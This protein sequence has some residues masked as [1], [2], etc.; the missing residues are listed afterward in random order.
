MIYNNVLGIIFANADEEALS[1]ITGIRSIGSVPFGGGYRLI[2]FTLSN[3]VNAG[4][5]KV[6]I[7][8]NNNYQSL[9]DHLGAGKPW[10]LSRRNEG[11]FLLPPFN[12]DAVRNYNAGR[13]GALKNAAHFLEKSNEEYALLSDCSYV[14]NIDF[15]R[16]FEEHE[17]NDADVTVLYKHGCVPHFSEQPV[18]EKTENGRIR[19]LSFA[20]EKEKNADYMIKAMLIKKSL[21]ESSV[22]ELHSKG[23]CS[24]EKDFIFKN[25]NK[26]NIR[27][28]EV[29]GFCEPIDSLKSYFEANFALLKPE[30]FKQL[31]ACGRPVYTKSYDDMPAVYGLGC[32]VKNS[33]VADGCIIEGEVENSIIFRGCRIEKDA[34]VKNSIVMPHAFI[35]Q[36]AMLNYCI[37]DKNVAIRNGKALSG[38]D[39]YP[40]YI[41]KNIHI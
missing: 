12:S 35:A 22:N 41:G 38:A 15:T 10:D 36:N 6:G 26:L 39:S 9:M 32:E 13:I 5:T 1:E 29:P 8:T 27:A 28:F 40:V 3:M 2:D 23:F 34:V 17:K 33:L 19:K 37:T 14:A 7:I 30:N 24:F 25:I 21:L 16:L 31:F 4:V 20:D 18:I 11:L